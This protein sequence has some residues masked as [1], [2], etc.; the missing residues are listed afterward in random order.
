M[1]SKKKQVFVSYIKLY[2]C[3]VLRFIIPVAASEDGPSVYMVFF[4]DMAEDLVGKPAD[5]L[6][7]E[8]YSLVSTT[9]SEISGLAGRKF[10]VDVTVFFSG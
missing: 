2:S 10:V 9:P 6:L 3:F 8:N 5:V 7:V 4:G 1:Y